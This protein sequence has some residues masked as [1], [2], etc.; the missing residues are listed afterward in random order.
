MSS[1]RGK[2]GGYVEQSNTMTFMGCSFDKFDLHSTFVT[3]FRFVG[4]FGPL[5]RYRYRE[6]HR[7]EKKALSS[8]LLTLFCGGLGMG[9]FLQQILRFRTICYPS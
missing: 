7:S 2:G 8:T 6:R 9:F 3:C 5:L 4:R 1:L